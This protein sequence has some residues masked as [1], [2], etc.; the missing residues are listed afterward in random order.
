MSGSSTC[1]FQSELGKF[2]NTK[3][4]LDQTFG[5]PSFEREEQDFVKYA[6]KL[7]IFKTNCLS[8]KGCNINFL[9]NDICY[10]TD[11][12][13][14]LIGITLYFPIHLGVR[15]KTQ[16]T[17]LQLF[18]GHPPFSPYPYPTPVHLL[19]VQKMALLFQM[20]GFPGDQVTLER[21]DPVRQSEVEREAVRKVS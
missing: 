15:I 7:M 14:L 1:C 20:P 3:V 18:C 19:I 10:L 6:K 16:G 9:F 4:C 17:A 5:F 21:T 2:H 12:S 8:F 13:Y 11:K